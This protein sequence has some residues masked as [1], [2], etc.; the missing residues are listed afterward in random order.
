[1]L[2]LL[3]PA[4][5]LVAQEPSI[6]ELVVTNTNSSVLLFLEV[7]NAFTK[8]MIQGMHNG[9]P[10][11]FTFSVELYRKRKGWLNQEIISFDFD[12]TMSYDTLKEE[13]RLDLDERPAK[14]FKTKG[15]TEAEQLMTQLNG[16]TVASLS[17]LIPDEEYI[18]RVKARQAEKTLPLYFH[19]VIPFWGLWD[20]ETDWYAIEFRY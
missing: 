15:F 9:I 11:A 4:S 3:L 6:V 8:E 19:Y 2:L 5:S 16:V 7:R 17:S 18:L 20:F 12:H 14:I 1:V 10:V 13:Y